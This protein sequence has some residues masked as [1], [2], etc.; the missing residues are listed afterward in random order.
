MLSAEDHYNHVLGI[1]DEGIA[2][3]EKEEVEKTV[4][5]SSQPQEVPPM[6]PAPME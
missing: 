1:F 6:C 4:T 5:P 2:V 3:L